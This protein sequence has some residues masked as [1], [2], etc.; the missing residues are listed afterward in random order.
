MISIIKYLNYKT[1]K[2]FTYQEDDEF[3]AKC[4]TLMAVPLLFS[5]NTYCLLIIFQTKQL[6]RAFFYITYLIFFT[7]NCFFV[8]LSNNNELTF[9]KLIFRD[10]SEVIAL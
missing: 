5:L 7:L 6:D 10:T 9:K 2:W 1:Y 4:S 3:T 8:F